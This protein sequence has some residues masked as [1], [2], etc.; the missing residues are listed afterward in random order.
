M[1]LQGVGEKK[2]SMLTDKVVQNSVGTTISESIWCPV[3]HCYN[4]ISGR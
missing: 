4:K 2:K 1:F 3:I